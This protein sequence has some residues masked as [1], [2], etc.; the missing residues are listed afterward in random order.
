MRI[1]S[2]PSRVKKLLLVAALLPGCFTDVE[3][4]P[5]PDGSTPADTPATDLVS[6]AHEVAVLEAGRDGPASPP[7]EAGSEH[8]IDASKDLPLPVD[9]LPQTPEVGTPDV[10]PVADSPLLPVP[11]ATPDLGRD[12]QTDIGVC[13]PNSKQCVGLQ[14]QACDTTGTWQ[15]TG[16]PCTSVCDNAT[17]SCTG[18]CKPSSKQCSGQQPQTC[19]ATGTWQNTG[20]ACSGCMICGTTT[21]VCVANDGVACDDGNACTQTDT[22]QSG[23][24]V[25]S[26]P[27]ACTASDQCHNAGVCDTASGVC[28]NPTKPLGF[29]CNDGN[30]CTESDA[31]NAAGT[32][33]GTQML[34]N[35]PPACKLSTTCSAGSCNYTQCSAHPTCL[36]CIAKFP[37]RAATLPCTAVSAVGQVPGICSRIQGSMARYLAGLLKPEVP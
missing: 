1:A 8:P 22:C 12:A 2:K 5:K 17:G 24:C 16:T 35:T 13:T 37:P 6:V 3:P 14:P 34:C 25:G 10:A 7:F 21:G 15:N 11:D 19:D 30:S 20:A 23:A 36:A 28:S 29:S 26:N 9:T 31:C 32:C 4:D 18:S 33:V 27:K